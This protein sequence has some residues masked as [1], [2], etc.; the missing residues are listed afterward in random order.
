MAILLLLLFVLLCN[1]TVYG[2]RDI[3]RLLLSRQSSSQP[4]LCPQSSGTAQHAVL[5]AG[6]DAPVSLLS[7]AGQSEQHVLMKVRMLPAAAGTFLQTVKQGEATNPTSCMWH[8]EYGSDH[9]VG[10]LHRT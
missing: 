3:P 2:S 10:S 4:C 6:G 5:L 9:A 8:P 7:H 1:S